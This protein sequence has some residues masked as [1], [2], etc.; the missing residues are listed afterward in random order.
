[1]AQKIRVAIIEDV[2]E[3]A[4]SLQELF[5]DEPDFQCNQVYNNAE[6]A[7]AFLTKA[8]VDIAIVD[9]GLP[10][11]SGI[12]MIK[13]L[14]Q[15]APEMEYCMFTVFEDEQK[16]FD[17]ITAGAKGYILKSDEPADIINAVREQFHGGSPMSPSI[18]RKVIEAFSRTHTEKKG[19]EELPLSV[20]Q[21]EILSLLSEGLLYKEIAARLNITVG[22]V[23]Q[24]IHNI[25][26]KLQVNNR[27]EAVNLYLNR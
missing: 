19:H 18:A 7:T 6:E 23:K 3:L 12:D 8:P 13:S 26:E 17:S 14:T 10:G 4:S 27:T 1:M 21:T 25:Y 22:T 15:Q 24:H 16:I 2:R 11:A 20:R 5:N 9:I